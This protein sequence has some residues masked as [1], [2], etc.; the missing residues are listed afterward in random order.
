M[1]FIVIG[2]IALGLKLSGQTP[3][4]SL[5]WWWVL[6]PFPAAVV[7]WV[8]ADAFGLTQRAQMKKMDR[9]REERRLKQMAALGMKDRRRAVRRGDKAFQGA[10]TRPASTI[11]PEQLAPKKSDD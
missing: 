10:L 1:W 4:A 8:F 9:R 7:W 5:D 11:I 2:V 6:A 3:I